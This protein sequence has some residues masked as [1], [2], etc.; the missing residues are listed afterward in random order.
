MVEK[1][2]RLRGWDLS[3]EIRAEI[4]R[5]SPLRMSKMVGWRPIWCQK[6]VIFGPMGFRAQLAHLWRRDIIAVL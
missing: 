2:L 5:I 6:G 1:K 3:G 4:L